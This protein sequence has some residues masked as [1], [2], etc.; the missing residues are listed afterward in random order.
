MQTVYV[1]NITHW[2]IS[3]SLKQELESHY[4][5]GYSLA[6][7]NQKPMEI[8][9]ALT[10]DGLSNSVTVEKL[11]RFLNL[12]NTGF[13]K[14]GIKGVGLEIGSGPGTFVAT[15]ANLPNVEHVYGV[16]ACESIVT[17]LM[18][19]VVAHIS[20]E[21]GYK[22]TGAIADFDHL[23]L[24]D[25]SLDFIFDFF[26]LHHSSNP[27]ITLKELARVLKPGGLIFCIDKARADSMTDANLEA[28]LDVE[29]SLE[30]KISM[31]IPPEVKHT[32]RMNGEHEY[33]RKDW[34]K[35]FEEAGFT[36][37]THYNAAKIAGATPI[38]AF[39]YFISLLPIRMQTLLSSHFSRR[40]TNNL[41]P[42]NRIFINIF[43]DYPR[44]FSLIFAWKK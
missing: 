20:G 42:S 35:Y 10:F 16:E 9:K 22:V 13:L 6:L 41:E 33:R 38:R 17:V 29:Y 8:V 23:S 44:E 28:L 2:E 24:K 7:S 3:D 19:K 25:N 30:G 26:S 34:K 14:N 18:E 27:A 15:F 5:T 11:T 32:R 39:K 37:F 1:M 31:G 36:N 4:K 40:V 12:L 21:N 43:P